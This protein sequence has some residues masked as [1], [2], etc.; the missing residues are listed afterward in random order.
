MAPE[1]Y[2]PGFSVACIAAVPLK[3]VQQIPVIIITSLSRRNLKMNHKHKTVVLAKMGM[4][5]AISIVLVAIIHFPIF[6]AV[7]FMEYDPADIPILIGTFAFGPVAGIVLTVV[8]SVIQGVT[9]SAGSGVYGIIMHI[10][11]TGVL[12][13]VAGTIYKFNKT[14][15]GA[16]IALIAGILAMTA[17]MMGANMIITPIFMG[18]PRSVVWDLMPFIA[19]FNLVKA[20][21]NAL[22]TFLLYKRVSAFLH[23]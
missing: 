23:R 19:A 9:V 20:G 14:R 13:I 15:K 7:A 6:P 17:A 11:A 1:I 21:V 8:T 5:V 4:L 22:V 18:V 2:F 12:V 16:V 3:P 10:I